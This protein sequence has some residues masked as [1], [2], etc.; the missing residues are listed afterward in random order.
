MEMLRSSRLMVASSAL[1]LACLIG[2]SHA[3]SQQRAKP[4]SD[5]ALPPISWTCPMH[6]DVVDP[7]VGTCPICK[8][9]LVSI[10]LDSIWTC[11][12]HSVI[13]EAKAGK[14]P[15]DGR[16]LIPMTVALTWTCAGRPDIDQIQPGTCADGTPMIAKHTA[17]PHGNHNPQHGGLFFMA[18]DNWHH[19]EGTY[20]RQGVMQIYLYDDYTKSLPQDQVQRVKGRIVTNETFDT[21]TRTTKEIAAFPLVSA[22]NG[23]YLEAKVDVKSLPAQ[24][25]AKV[26]F[27]DEGPEYRFDFAFPALSKEP[28]ASLPVPPTTR[29]TAGRRGSPPAPAAASAPIVPTI[30]VVA[31]SVDAS[32][33]RGVTIPDT[34]DEML[35]ELRSR[36]DQIAG[37]I[38]R[39]AFAEVWVPAL[40]AK[41]L[42][43]ALD[44]HSGQWP[45]ERRK[46]AEPAIK[47]LVRT[48]WLLDAL[49]DLGNRQQLTE[50]YAQFASAVAAV[51][52]QPSANR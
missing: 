1:L 8:M 12:V 19:L 35:V 47:R 28:P 23:Q 42:A 6:P 14:C 5:I 41:D 24:M 33:V 34:V 31:P 22:R 10:R 40:Q 51:D 2:P 3:F 9:N 29:P 27:K 48:A 37:L 21:A 49:G 32:Q 16:E 11:P 26:K 45:L 52:A 50:A 17:R 25:S 30:V 38:Q 4:A 46:T 13:A 44:A 36:N 39:G 18:A 7:K 15:I 43:L 20:P